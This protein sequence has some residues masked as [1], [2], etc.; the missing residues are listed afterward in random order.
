VQ[1]SIT[2][3]IR[4][5]TNNSYFVCDNPLVIDR[6]FSRLRSDGGQVSSTF[7]PYSWYGI[8]KRQP[9]FKDPIR[10]PIYPK[11]I[12]GLEIT[13]VV[14]LTLGYDS[15]NPPTYKPSLPLSSGHMIQFRAASKGGLKIVLTTRTSGTE[16]KVR[17]RGMSGKRMGRYQLFDR[18]NTTWKG[19]DKTAMLFRTY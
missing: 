17:M 4:F 5:Q 18:S 7:G 11:S 15:T 6:I 12:A 16:P 3:L 8:V 14:D 13:S 19:V 1:I 2:R 9:S 10:R